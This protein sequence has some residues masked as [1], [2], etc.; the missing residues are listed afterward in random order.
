MSADEH[1]PTFSVARL[2]RMFGFSSLNPVQ[3]WLGS[4]LLRASKT[5]EG[6]TVRHLVSPESVLAF[7]QSQPDAYD[8]RTISDERLKAYARRVEERDPLVPIG[9]L[10]ASTSASEPEL[11]GLA[12]KGVIPLVAR[13]SGGRGG[14]KRSWWIRR[15]KM[16]GAAAAVSQARRVA[17]PLSA[18]HSLLDRAERVPAPTAAGAAAVATAPTSR[19]TSAAAL[20]AIKCPRCG[21]RMMR[22]F[23]DELSEDTVDKCLSCGHELPVQAK[24]EGPK[25]LAAAAGWA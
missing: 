25:A 17:D 14:G 12:R 22:T 13:G 19:L 9:E 23:A 3:A 1:T 5:G 15:S 24:N 8:W 7:V 18:L 16:A 10:A 2:A 21:S 20:P 6:K 11:R 4:G